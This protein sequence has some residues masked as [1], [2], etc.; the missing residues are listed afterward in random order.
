MNLNFSLR[1][2]IFT[3]A[4]FIIISGQII[5]AQINVED[6]QDSYLKSMQKKMSKMGE[7]LQND[8]EY[9]I[10]L[11][12][13]ITKLIRVEDTLQ[14]TL[15]AAPELEFIEITDLDKYVLYY[16]DHQSIG[17]VEPNT[18]LS[19]TIDAQNNKQAKEISGLDPINLDITVPIFSTHKK[20][21]VG[22][23]KMRISPQLVVKKSREI[24]LDQI[25][26]ILVSLLVTFEFLSFFIAYT[27]SD[28]LHRV[29]DKLNQ[30]IKEKSLLE[31]EQF[32]FM[33]ELTLL[34]KN[35]NFFNKKMQQYLRPFT[36]LQQHHQQIY[37][38][39]KT[40]REQTH[41]LGNLIEDKLNKLHTTS[42][43][44]KNS[45]QLLQQRVNLIAPEKDKVLA[46]LDMLHKQLLALQQK[47]EDLLSHISPT[48]FSLTPAE[49]NAIPSK[50]PEEVLPYA[51][52][53]PLVFLICMATGFSLSFFP[54]FVNTLYVPFFGLS[55]EMVLGLPIS[56]FMLFFA[57][58]ML[59]TGNWAQ[60]QGWKK[61]LLIGV[62][63]HATG[64]IFTAYASQISELLF[65][66]AFT[67]VGFGIILMACQQYII[68][69]TKMNER[70]VG[71]AAFIAALVGGEIVGTVIG[72]MLAGR[73]GYSNVFLLAASFSIIG[74]IYILIVFKNVPFHCIKIG[75]KNPALTLK[76]VLAPFRSF[77]FFSIIFLQAIPAKIAYVGFLTYF[78][79]LYLS[80]INILQS[81]IGRVLMGYG[82]MM[83][84]VGP[85]FSRLF[86]Q[87]VLR[88]YLV[89][90]GG[91]LT[92]LSML[93]LME[94][95]GFW[96][97]LF[98]VVGLGMGQ[99]LS[100]SAQASYVYDID[101]VRK[102]GA[103]TGMGVFRFWERIGN[104]MGPLLMSSL[105]VS[106]GFESAVVIL[107]WLTLILTTLYL[108]TI[109]IHKKTP[110]AVS[111]FFSN[112][113]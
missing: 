56:V 2:K 83:V 9:I 22:Y 69:N 16:A 42:L 33:K 44:S 15:Y 30:A 49:L 78:V 89:F 106:V 108:I 71:M 80:N 23:I 113:C 91:T 104:V 82:L 24:L 94:Y 4:V 8:V 53:R 84:F 10:N 32:L 34:I 1:I 72:G 40:C 29:A 52:I 54:M 95:N 75:H 19:R 50:T 18:R 31:T 12:I 86:S 79:P 101:I 26:V 17:R 51:Y 27:I 39:Q 66:R 88:K 87:P 107:G 81:D 70:V 47:I 48:M 58:S 20:K 76:V 43:P 110:Q 60:S 59:F 57:L 100:V 77:E 36:F 111:S 25:T 5:Y 46:N 85:I 7:F 45:Y 11:G 6:F 92:G 68:D 105:I 112:R 64:L 109:F 55:K 62:T 61:P 67:A 99:A 102:M 3:L 65:Y 28:P 41:D 37:T 93:I 13:P 73:I 38:Y 74:F 90:V 35:F 63:I 96:A 98:I 97:V 14:E 21:Q 103:G